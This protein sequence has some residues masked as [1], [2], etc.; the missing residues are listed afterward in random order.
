MEKIALSG[1]LVMFL[2]ACATAGSGQ[3][4]LEVV[5]H[6]DL[7]RYVGRWYEIASFPQRF[8][9]GCSDSRAEYRILPDGNV[10]VLNSCLKDGKVD[11]A[12]GRAWVV[13]TKTNAKLKVSFFW[14]FRGDYWIIDLEKDYEYAVVSAPS[15][16][17]LW[18]LS[19]TPTM[20]EQRYQAIVGRLKDRGFDITKLNRTQQGKRKD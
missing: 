7:G 8:Q 10:E 19:R 16:K 15:M 3:A 2:Y 17:Y 20:E 12:K 14:P 1:T 11:T 9:K 5:P 4:P 18:I 6:V 13:D